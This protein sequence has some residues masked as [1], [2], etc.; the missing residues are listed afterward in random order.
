[1]KIS[2]TKIRQIDN[3]FEVSPR[4]VSVVV[5]DYYVEPKEATFVYT[6]SPGN[7]QTGSGDQI[8]YD[9]K[10]SVKLEW[11]ATVRNEFLIELGQTYG[12]F[13]RNQFVT[14]VTQQ[15]KVTA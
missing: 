3:G 11:P 14:Q 15:Q 6:I 5:L 1:M 13:T 10:N 7:V 12:I 9:E 4:N 2:L 8:I